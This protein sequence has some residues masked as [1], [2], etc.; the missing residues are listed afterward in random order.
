MLTDE[1][2]ALDLADDRVTTV[3]VVT[4]SAPGDGRAAALPASPADVH[5]VPRAGAAAQAEPSGPATA[6]GP[7]DLP[8]PPAPPTAADGT[9][10][11]LGVLNLAV[12]VVAVLL[13]GSLLLGMVRPRSLSRV[14]PL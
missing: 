8:T 10:D 2:R 1:P 5:W 3:A 12:L 13:V 4:T 9:T 14:Q 6:T 11:A 7:A